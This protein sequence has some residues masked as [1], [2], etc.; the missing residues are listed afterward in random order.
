MIF[1]SPFHNLKLPI[2]K[3]SLKLSFSEK[4]TKIDKIFTVNLRL[5]SNLQ[6]DGEDFANFC[7]LLRNY[8]LYPAI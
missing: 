6:M 5:C 8:E 7:G 4:A 2:E 3:V 1:I